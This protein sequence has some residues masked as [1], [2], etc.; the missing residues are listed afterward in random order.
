MSKR[1]S[2]VLGGVYKLRFDQVVSVSLTDI[3]YIKMVNLS[4]CQSWRF[5]ICCYNLCRLSKKKLWCSNIFPGNMPWTSFHPDGLAV[6]L[7]FDHMVGK[8]LTGFP[9]SL[10]EFP[11]TYCKAIWTLIRWKRSSKFWHKRNLL[12]AKIF[13]AQLLFPLGLQCQQI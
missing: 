7:C 12:L 2:R 11:N 4:T 8:K 10:R 3:F 13:L 1:Q 5:L 9:P 6:L